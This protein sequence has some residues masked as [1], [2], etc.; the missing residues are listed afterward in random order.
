[1]F[2]EDALNGE[3]VRFLNKYLIIKP[4]IGVIKDSIY[5]CRTKED[6]FS[7]NHHRN[8]N[9][10]VDSI[11]YVENFLINLSKSLYNRIVPFLQYLIGYNLFLRINTFQNKESLPKFKLSKYCETIDKLLKLVED[12]YILEQ[13]F[14]S[15]NYKLFALYKKYNKD[16]RYDIKFENNSFF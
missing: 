9:F 13:K 16:L 3:D 5:Y 10:C 8:L 14:I 1:M 11:Y 4:I 12:K 2:D 6:S 7:I 15:N